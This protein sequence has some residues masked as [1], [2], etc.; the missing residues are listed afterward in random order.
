MLFWDMLAW[1]PQAGKSITFSKA[2]RAGNYTIH[3]PDCFVTIDKLHICFKELP[4]L[5]GDEIRSKIRKLPQ[6]WTE[7][8]NLHDVLAVQ[9]AL[10]Q[11][12]IFTLFP[13]NAGNVLA[14][15]S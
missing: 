14:A 5:F 4:K 8:H 13:C 12:S 15:A 3:H 11:P 7:L 2:A 6:C 10:P 1:Q 9:S